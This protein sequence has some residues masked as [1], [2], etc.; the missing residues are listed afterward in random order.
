MDQPA[1]PITAALSPPLPRCEIQ[2][3]AVSLVMQ[4]GPERLWDWRTVGSVRL[5]APAPV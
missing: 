4:Y 1:A 5:P 2:I 3:R